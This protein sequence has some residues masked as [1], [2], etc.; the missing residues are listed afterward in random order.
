MRLLDTLSEGPQMIGISVLYPYMINLFS[1]NQSMNYDTL[2][3]ISRAQLVDIMM[4]THSGS[5]LLATRLIWASQIN[6]SNNRPM[7]LIRHQGV[8]E[9]W[10][11]VTLTTQQKIFLNIFGILR[12]NKNRV[13]E[14]SKRI[15]LAGLKSGVGGS[16]RRLLKY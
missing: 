8:H 3:P 9:W 14:G 1:M 10:F 5:Q 15:F 13:V 2:C 7:P 16:P 12:Y 11:T 4:M 6:G